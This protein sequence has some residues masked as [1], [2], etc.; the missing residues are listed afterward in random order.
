MLPQRSKHPP[1]QVFLIALGLVSLLAGCTI[2]SPVSPTYHIVLDKLDGPRGLWLRADGTLC[3]A[4]GGRLAEGQEAGNQPA[5]VVAESGAV[6]CIDPAGHRERIAEHLPY[7]LYSGSGVSVGTT[8][9]AELNG[10]LYGL[11]WRF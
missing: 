4:E 6:T 7:V 11:T 9:L 5:T 8:D 1:A 10:N 3:V 2:A